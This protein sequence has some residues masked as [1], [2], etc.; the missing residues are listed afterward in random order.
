MDEKQ[1]IATPPV[2]PTQKLNPRGCTKDISVTRTEEQGANKETTITF[3]PTAFLRGD[4]KTANIQYPSPGDITDE[5]LPVI[6]NWL[7][8]DNFFGVLNEALR[9]WWQQV[10]N[11]VVENNNGQFDET[12][13]KQYLQDLSTR[14]ESMGDLEDKLR[15]LGTDLAN[16]SE[17]M[18]KFISSPAKTPQEQ[19]EMAKIV[20]EFQ[21][22][23]ADSQKYSKA[24]ESKKRI[25]KS[26]KTD[27]DD[28]DS[29][30]NVPANVTTV[31]A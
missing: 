10:F 27:S 29:G 25:R 21:K 22:I 4:N 7:G 12:L 13:C 5:T 8:N 3:S 9:L 20:G 23:K 30:S 16:V 6:K 26:K 2:A 18:L 31:K 1:I 15:A 11:S 14:G 17:K 28:N 19:Q 24:I